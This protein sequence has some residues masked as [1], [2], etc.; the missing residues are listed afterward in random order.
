MFA[1]LYPEGGW[2]WFVRT[3]EDAEHADWTELVSRALGPGADVRADVSRVQHWVMNAFVAERFRHGRTLLAGDAAHAM[4]IVG[5]LGMN[6]G[7][8]DVHNLCWKLA[9]VLHGWAGPNLLDTYETERQP[10]AHQTLEQAVTNTQLMLQVQNR[11]R[12]QLHAGEAAP[13]RIELP[14]SDR[15]FAQL[16]LVL[17][18]TYHSDAVL[19]DNS[20]PYAPPAP[21][22]TGST[23]YVP[24]AKPGH[25]M[26]HLW[27]THDRST[28]D[29]VGEWFTLLTPDPAHWEQRTTTPW[30]LRIE[31]LPDEHI[32]VCGLR[33][34]GALLIR[35]DGHIGACWRDRPP[36][37]FALHRALTAITGSASS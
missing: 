22:D 13:D 17:G 19:T 30:P 35:P 11:R 21:P 25:R 9:G 15:F 8:A 32:D 3:P 31:T 16:G 14:W 33:P 6:A 29:A 12:D 36:G 23:D 1:P 2:A 18:V 10:V 5:G 24:T 20:T 26:P 7:I 37:D 28:L 34:H 4:P 27:L